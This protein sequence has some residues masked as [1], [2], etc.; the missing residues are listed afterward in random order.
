MPRSARRYDLYLP[1][2]DNTGR[3]LADEVFDAV[4][5]RL[6][7]RFGGLT[8]QQRDFPLRGIWQ[9][10]ARLYLD[11]VIVMTVLDFRRQGSPRFVAQLKRDLLR[12]LDQ[13]EILITEQPLRVH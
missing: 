7:A 4:E 9:G 5:R 1:L 3:P 10:A 8:S 6:L 11:Q 13:L 12:E 2:T